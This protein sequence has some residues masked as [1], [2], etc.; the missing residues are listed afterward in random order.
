[1]IQELD[2]L[3]VKIFINGRCPLQ[4]NWCIS[5]ASSRKFL[6]VC[7]NDIIIVE[8]VHLLNYAR[9]LKFDE[10]PSYERI[11]KM[12]RNVLQN[13]I[14]KSQNIQ[15]TYD[16]CTKSSS[17]FTAPRISEKRRVLHDFLENESRHRIK[18]CIIK[19]L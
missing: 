12:L 7:V 16:W 5:K 11:Q 3:T 6:I 19:H 17:S 14:N 10:E 8:F 2:L 9:A 18:R 4:L 1:M 13:D 15:F